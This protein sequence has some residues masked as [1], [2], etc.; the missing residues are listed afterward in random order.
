MWGGSSDS[1]TLSEPI[2]PLVKREHYGLQNRYERVRLPHGSLEITNYNMNRTEDLKNKVLSLY[3]LG[4]DA[5][6]ISKEY[7]ISRGTLYLWLK[8][9][10]NGQLNFTPVNVDIEEEK[11]NTSSVLEDNKK[12][13]IQIEKLKDLVQYYQKCCKNL[14]ENINILEQRLEKYESLDLMENREKRKY[15]KM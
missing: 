10:K 2:E 12:L 4:S 3:D 9:R 14:K 15:I 7:G 5:T 6:K 1:S 11:V 8:Q 13:R